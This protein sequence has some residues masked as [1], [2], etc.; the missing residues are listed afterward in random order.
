MMKKKVKMSFEQKRERC[1]ES[2]C[3]KRRNMA[4]K[5]N[6]INKTR[7]IRGGI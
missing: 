7:I 2:R 6:N 4:R 5:A 1:G 3:K